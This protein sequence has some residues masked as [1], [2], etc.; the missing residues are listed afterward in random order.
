[1]HSPKLGLL[2]IY[3]HYGPFC[4]HIP[5][6]IKV[7]TLY[8]NVLWGTSEKT[9]HLWIFWPE[10]E[11]EYEC[12][13]LYSVWR[14]TRFRFAL[15]ICQSTPLSTHIPLPTHK[16]VFAFHILSF[17][18]T[19]YIHSSH[20]QNVLHLTRFKYAFQICQSSSLSI[21]IPEAFHFL[22]TN[23]GFLSIYYESGPV[24]THICPTS[25]KT[26]HVHIFCLEQVREL[27]YHILIQNALYLALGFAFRTCQ[28]G[29]YTYSTPYTQIGVFFPYI[30]NIDLLPMHIPPTNKMCTLYWKVLWRTSEK[31]HHLCII[32]LEQV[33]KLLHLST[34][35]YIQLYLGLLF[36]CQSSLLPTH[37][38]LTIT[39]CTMYCI[40]Y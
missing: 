16:F 22:Y 26:H 27:E 1:M 9:H 28:F 31:T 38:H 12:H 39:M 32:C 10:E 35:C 11:W 2:S 13:T 14:L 23:L 29:F 33:W 3:C 21:H 15:H 18:S 25:E 6:R 7:C 30:L 36:T 24:P 5:P 4:T 8:C 17:Q 34:M 37:I 40:V 19:P 20:N